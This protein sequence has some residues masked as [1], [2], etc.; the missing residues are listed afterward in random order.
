M[1]K[2]QTNDRGD[3]LGKDH[4]KSIDGGWEKIMQGSVTEET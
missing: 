3:L 2:T 4:Q 1:T